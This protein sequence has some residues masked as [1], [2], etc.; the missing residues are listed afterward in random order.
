VVAALIAALTGCGS[1]DRIVVGSK[2][3]AEQ[4]VLGEIVA[5]HLER[6]GFQV[7]RRL[8][9]GG[10]LLAHEAL[11]RGR[12]DLYP[13]YTGTALTTVLKQAPASDAGEVLRRVRDG[14]RAWGLE[15]LDPL[16]FNNTFAMVIRGKDAR[17]GHFKT[18]SDAERRTWVLGVGYEFVSRPDGLAGLERV[19]HL[20][21]AGPP[22]TMDLGLLYQALEQGQIDMA[23]GNST[24]GLIAA[25]DFVIL[26]DDRHFFPPYQAA[27]VVR[28]AALSPTV[29]KTLSALS[30][31][32]TDALM[33]RL[34]YEVVG[35]HRPIPAVARE[36]LRQYVTPP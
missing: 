18:L 7:E 9:L 11:R 26:E 30:G 21:L 33:R 3:F 12:I 22:N 27:L 6:A 15:W 5:Q 23:A 35:M 10:T 32:F 19:Y 17:R 28:E 20:P 16:G 1:R 29:R 13:E 4:L 25:G 36:F 34:N 14:Y 31:R 8:N 2:N 24:D